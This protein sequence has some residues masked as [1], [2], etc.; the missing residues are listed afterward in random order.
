MA[1]TQPVLEPKPL[2][3][4]CEGKEREPVPSK[5]RDPAPLQQNQTSYKLMNPLWDPWATLTPEALVE[6]GGHPT[7]EHTPGV[8]KQTVCHLPG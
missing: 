4:K 6:M 1:V 5:F 3:K 2:A 7:Q 8:R